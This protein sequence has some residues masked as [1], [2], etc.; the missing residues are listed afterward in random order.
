MGTAPSTDSLRER[1][2]ARTR[3]DL[4][5]VSQRRFAEHGYHETTLEEISAEVGVRPQTLLRYFESKAH[6]ALAP[7]AEQL[8]L[9][10]R[11]LTDPGRS[12]DTLTVWRELVQLEAAEALAPTSAFTGNMIT[13]HA[14]FTA[15][16][17]KDRF[18]VA[19]NSDLERQTQAVLAEALASDRGLEADDLHTTMV[20]AM[21]VVGRRAVYERWSS[22]PG[23]A[24]E[25]LL[26]ELLAVIDYA[27]TALAARPKALEDRPRKC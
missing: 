7:W 6:L 11:L 2:K 8:T 18:L 23:E 5:R 16:A 25:S 15:W 24:G 26:D 13:N 3:A 21:L 14:A 1:K 27:G 9:L 12:A 22:G 17:D 19:L 10:R 20:A 4:I